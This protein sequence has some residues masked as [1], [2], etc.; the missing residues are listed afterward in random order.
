M[1]SIQNFRF[2][3]LTGTVMLW[4]LSLPSL[5]AAEASNIKL[6]VYFEPDGDSYIVRG[7][8]TGARLDRGGVLRLSLPHSQ[9]FSLQFAGRNRAMAEPKDLLP[10]R[11]HY[12][13]GRDARKWRTNVPQFG[14]VL[15]RNVYPGIDVDFH[16]EAGA[17]EYD[18]IVAPGADP[19]RIRVA[20]SGADA[21]KI[22]GGDLLIQAGGR[23][24]RHAK[25]RIY[26]R[27]A[28]GQVGVEGRYAILSNGEVRIDLDRYDSTRP[29]VID[30]RIVYSTLLG[31]DDVDQ[32]RS[33]AVD[34]Q[35]NV[36]VTGSAGSSNFPGSSSPNTRTR[37]QYASDAYVAKIDPTGSKLLYTAFFGSPSYDDGGTAIAMD[38]AGNA[39]VTGTTASPD[40]P[41]TSNA[42]QKKGEIFLLKLDP[43]GSKLL[44]STLFGGSRHDY[45]QALAINAT[46]HAVV[47]GYTGSTDFP[48]ASSM[49]SPLGG[50]FDAFVFRVD[51]TAGRLIYSSAFGGSDYDQAYGVALDAGGNAYVTGSTSSK[52]FPTS[53]NAFQ[54]SLKGYQNAFVVK[55]GPAGNSM[56]STLFGGAAGYSN[57]GNAIAVD[58]AGNAYITGSTNAPD[59]PTTAL[60][61]G[62]KTPGGGAEAFIT[63]LNP[64]GSALQYSS[65]I[66]GV[67]TDGFG[68]A[69]TPGGEA[70]VTGTLLHVVS[71]PPDFPMV[72]P[73][74]RAY[75]GGYSEGFLCRVDATGTALT[76]STFIGGMGEEAG[77]S[78]LGGVALDAAG[79]VYVAGFSQS[80]DFPATPGSFQP[81]Y[82][83]YTT[84]AS[85]AGEGFIV[86]IDPTRDPDPVV[87]TAG[88]HVI[89]TIAGGGTLGGAT[90][91]PATQA[92][93]GQITAMTLD[94]SGN[95]VFASEG[96]GASSI[97]GGG[98]I[99]PGS[100]YGG[101]IRLMGPDGSLHT[102][103]AADGAI[104][105]GD[106]GP[107]SKAYIDTA[108]GL[109]I[110]AAGNIYISET[111]E[112]VVWKIGVD[113]II[114]RIAGSGS[115]GTGGDGGPAR[116]AQLGSPR[117]LAV[118]K[119]G[120][121]YI[122]DFGTGRVRKV[123]PDGTI[124][125]IAGGGTASFPAANGGQATHASL[126]RPTAL[127]LDDAG[128]LYIVDSCSIFKVT[129][130]G[131]ITTVAGTG[132]MN[133][134][135][136]GDGRTAVTA[137]LNYPGGMA[138]AP[139]G[140]LYIADT[141]NNR[142]RRITSGGMIWNVAGMLS[143]GSSGDNGPGELAQLDGPLAI[144]F[145]SA[146][147]LYIAENHRIRKL[148][149]PRPLPTFDATGVVTSAGFR[150]GARIAQ[151]SIFTI[152]GAYMGPV[153]GMATP[154]YPLGAWLA[155]VTIVVGQG[156]TSKNAIPIYVS[157]SQVNA[158]M[159]SDA[160]LGD[161]QLQVLYAGFPT[162]PVTVKVVPASFQ[163]FLTGDQNA[164]IFQ[165]VAS[166]TSYLLNT[167]SAPAQPGEIVIG[168]GTG[169]GAGSGPDMLS[170]Q[171][172]SLPVDVQVS[173]GGKPAQVLYKGRAPTFAGVDNIY[174][175]IPSD[176]PTGCRVP[177][178]VGAGGVDSE[179][180][181]LAIST[182]GP[183]Q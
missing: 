68:I 80:A 56:Y 126:S 40:F 22:D 101:P 20:I 60:L 50:V 105:A 64:E 156:A 88:D 69:L 163:F 16:A 75:G 72:N 150:S 21:L 110:D 178:Q 7:L 10:G 44:Y 113:G 149:L 24:L 114:H 5:F 168:W 11:T 151:G 138:F 129:P 27:T 160:P 14:R 136:N 144:A 30:P 45:A 109:A 82:G 98:T 172:I 158:I 177:V 159:P 142:V 182:G 18:F 166:P 128:N 59:F 107:V 37:T 13:T 135:F 85:D 103:T 133:R 112:K 115:Y 29:L 83:G 148:A 71:Y 167:P 3:N 39:F 154:G 116:N 179:P 174:F 90:S 23:W 53:G 121:L 96:C 118:D 125:T 89:T 170:P 134:V 100:C 140:D 143:A 108:R 84:A 153:A 99:I 87:V 91:G 181:T 46:G 17:L 43:S 132:V 95:V 157:A 6:P 127:A 63:K 42:V 123:A 33:I 26:Q 106:G 47:A 111:D 35:G 66:G 74:Q 86:K 19:R 1:S 122:A 120:S 93:I 77:D 4:S 155:D 52:D 175:V 49:P 15:F 2:L 38:A 171:G 78:R 79:N 67:W 92:A 145:D 61:P 124:V 28:T 102:L 58:S 97:G 55:V 25:P 51:T 137:T 161:V 76:F 147:N 32:I 164:G 104:D 119:L 62:S 130:A 70:W 173:V 57:E 169:L 131:I 31:G 8:K 48:K 65:P 54:K 165:N 146:G 139:N 180:V 141:S 81:H 36:Y 41:V 73:T 34:S 9:S 12:F 117:G 94:P 183:C 162:A 152:F 176:A